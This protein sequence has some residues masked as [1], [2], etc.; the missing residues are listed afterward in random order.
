MQEIKQP[1]GARRLV[2]WSLAGVVVVG[3]A[4]GGLL[5]ARRAD[6]KKKPE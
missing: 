3:V 2:I 6:G 5:M 1:R 4:T